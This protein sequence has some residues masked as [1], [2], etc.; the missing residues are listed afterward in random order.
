MSV[1]NLLSLDDVKEATTRLTKLQYIQRPPDKTVAGNAFEGSDITYQF[2]TSGNQWWIPSKSYFTMRCKVGKDATATQ[3]EMKDQV[4]PAPMFMSG[5]FQAVDFRIAGNSVCRIGSNLPQVEAV[6]N[7]LTKSKGWRESSG[8]TNFFTSDFEERRSAISADDTEVVDKAGLG[9]GGAT[10]IALTANG[11]LTGATGPPPDFQTIFEEGDVVAFIT[12]GVSYSYVVDAAPSATTVQFIG[13]AGT[14][15]VIAAVVPTALTRT[16]AG[17]PGDHRNDIEMT[18]QPPHA[19]FSIDTPQP[20]GTYSVVLSPNANNK[21]QASIQTARGVS[22]PEADVVVSRM[23]LNLCVVDGETPPKDMTHYLDLQHVSAQPQT[24][25]PTTGEQNYDYV[26]SPS[27]YA[28]TL[29]SQ[30]STAGKDT[31]Y[32]PQIF[33]QQDDEHLSLSRFRIQ[34]AGQTRDSPD[35]DPSYAV[36]K[37]WLMKQYNDTQMNSNM[38]FNEG[39]CETYED[40]LNGFA[41]LYH[42]Q[43]LKPAGDTSSNANVAITFNTAPTNANLFVCDWS[44]R[45]VQIVY[46]D[47]R[48]YSV[49]TE[50]A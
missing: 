31:Q 26:V 42:R 35:A 44:S 37:S 12:A 2:T 34:Y 40:W 47:G 24:L 49:Q 33:K 19:I 36:D 32:P 14:F 8:R 28:L 10:T 7:R 20:P 18:W 23:L 41:P 43:F 6:R 16:R 11:L 25:R 22:F 21:G 9:F 38:Y 5:M 17:T 27:T 39:G 4:A 46:R 45:V 13:A 29:F 1:S 30:Q 15:P 50:S 48:L 3:P